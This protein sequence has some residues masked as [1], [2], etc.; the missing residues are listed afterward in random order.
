MLSVAHIVF[1]I[2]NLYNSDSPLRGQRRTNELP[3]GDLEVFTEKGGP[4]KSPLLP[5]LE[6][7]Q[8]N[9]FQWLLCKIML[10]PLFLYKFFLHLPYPHEHASPKVA[11][12]AVGLFLWNLSHFFYHR[13][14]STAKHSGESPCGYQ[15]WFWND[16][17]CSWRNVKW[18]D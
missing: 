9:V 5:S 13:N 1:W 16:N 12:L 8:I 11:Q 14:C 15:R 4:A 17:N 6:I 2:K 3:C 10:S 7:A 18:E